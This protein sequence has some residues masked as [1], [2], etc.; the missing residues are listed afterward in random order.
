MRLNLVPLKLD[1]FL[2]IE[3]NIKKYGELETSM[4]SYFLVGIYK[5]HHADTT[6]LAENSN[7]MPKS[8]DPSFDA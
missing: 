5:I 8:L 4:V 6:T 2:F 1:K 3:I 7:W